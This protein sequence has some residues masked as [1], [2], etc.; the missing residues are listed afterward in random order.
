MILRE[1]INNWG[2]YAITDREM[3]G[4]LTHTEIAA[5]LMDG[6]IRVIQ[7]RDKTTPYDR[8]LEDVTWV[9]R[10][11]RPL[12]VTVIVNDNP[13]LARDADA[14]GVHL[15]QTDCPV[16]TARDIVGPDRII[17]LSTHTRLQALRAQTMDVDYIGLGPIYTTPTKQQSYLPLGL[18]TVRWAAATLKIPFVA[19]GGIT[20]DNLGDVLAAG[21]RHCAMI[22]A[23]MK[24]DD[25]TAAARHFL[26]ICHDLWREDDFE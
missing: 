19:I 16:S 21:A 10:M 14:D 24:A 26:R 2:I 22:S 17:G 1:T 4:G 9:V 25:I 13:Y 15:G 23:L 6:G 5:K 3:T 11:A 20:A 12:G 8:L 7:I 18:P